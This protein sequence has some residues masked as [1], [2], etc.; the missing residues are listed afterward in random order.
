[1]MYKLGIDIGSTTAKL[2]V[3]DENKSVV[4]S[5]YTRHNA[6]V[7]CCVAD[8]LLQAENVIGN[9]QAEVVITGSAG[10]GLSERLGLPFVQEVIAVSNFVKSSKME[11]NTLIDIGGEDAK[12]IFFDKG[13]MPLMRMNGNCAGGTG[14][15]I[16][17]M[18]VVLGVAV[19]ELDALAQRAEH[20]Y[21]IA[22]RCGVFSKTDVQN[23]VAKAVS[24]QDI[25]AS[26]FNAIALQVISSLS[27]GLPIKPKILLCG[28]PLTYI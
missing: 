17:Q 18:A 16:D 20:I 1:M 7:A 26:I 23:L 10:L 21:P 11:I 4:Y 27:K 28:G 19:E 6:D 8:I 3:Q 24:K 2:V 12:I 13:Q 22:S 5:K 9:V 25:A 14:A 15:F